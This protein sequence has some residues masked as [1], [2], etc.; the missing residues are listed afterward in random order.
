MGTSSD[1]SKSKDNP[2]KNQNME[3]NTNLNT[4]KSYYKLNSSEVENL[5]NEYTQT[6]HIVSHFYD[7]KDPKDPTYNILKLE[8]KEILSKY[9]ESTRNNFVNL[10]NA[11]LLRAQIRIDEINKLVKEF[12]EKEDGESAFQYK[13]EECIKKIEKNPKDYEIK[14]LTV[15][16]VGKSGVGKSTLINEV[17]KLEG[18]EKAQIGTGQFVTVKYQE[19][20]SDSLEFLKLI[21]T[22]GIELNKN[23]GADEVKREASKFIE[24]R[25]ETND[26]NKFVQCIWYCITGNRFEQVEQNLLTSL[27]TTYGES[28]IPIILIYTQATDKTAIDEMKEYIKKIN[29]EVNFIEVLAKRKELVQNQGALEPFGIDELIKETLK[30]CKKALNGEMFSVITESISKKII[31]MLEKQNF[32]DKDYITRMMKLSFINNFGACANKETF[33]HFIIHLL[34]FNIKIFFEKKELKVNENCTEIFLNSDLFINFIYLMINEYE[35]IADNLIEPMLDIKA[36]EFI[37]L[38]VDVQK[39]C[40]KEISFKNQRKINDFRINIKD[41]LIDNY[42]LIAQKLIINYIFRNI[43]GKI[44]NEFVNQFNFLTRKILQRDK[45]KELIKDCFMIKFSDF[46]NRLNSYQSAL[47]KSKQKFKEKINTINIYN[48]S[49]EMQFNN[50]N[51]INNINSNGNNEKML[52]TNNNVF[53][54][55][56]FRFVISGRFQ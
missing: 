47:Y 30:K 36:R 56:C 46:E 7:I 15:M 13:I 20:S 9:L 8:E 44:T 33:L 27:R 6:K 53:G 40:Q 48:T 34:G 50:I 19:Y 2:N 55:N 22:R 5:Y 21:D 49:N 1:A 17:L 3:N 12:I 38:Q 41:F 28:K 18:N 54:F 52:L 51:K 29:I 35:N 42:H 39:K 10:F 23:Y 25:K 45:N 16:L 37:D 24:E 43:F 11:K 4:P 26:P 32:S 31:E 14:Y